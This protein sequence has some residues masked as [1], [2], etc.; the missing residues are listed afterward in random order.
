MK[1]KSKNSMRFDLTQEKTLQLIQKHDQNQQILLIKTSKTPQIKTNFLNHTNQIQNLI[2]KLKPTDTPTNIKSTIYLT[3]SFIN[4]T[5]SDLIYLI[6][7]NTDQNLSN[8]IK[9]NPKIKPIIITN[10]K[11]NINITKFEFQQHI[12]NNDQYKFMLEIKNFHHTTI[13]YPIHLSID[14]TIL[15]ER[16]ISFETQEKQILMIPYTGL[17]NRITRAALEIDDDFTVDNR[18]YLSLNTAKEI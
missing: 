3:L 6:T 18:T 14:R 10:S 17:I 1:T 2:N 4:P 9:N 13:K 11:Q 15:L 12:N 8:L 16:M 5:K 7:N